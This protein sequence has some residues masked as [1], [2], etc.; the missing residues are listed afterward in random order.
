[1]HEV[2]E[3]RRPLNRARFSG[4]ARLVALFLT[5]PCLFLL[6]KPLDFGIAFLFAIACWL[7]VGPVSNP[8][9]ALAGAFWLGPGIVLVNALAGPQPRLWGLLS[10]AGARLG[11]A[12]ALRLLW[13]AA[14]AH[15]LVRTCSRDEL[16]AALRTVLR[17][18]HIPERHAITIF[19]TLQ[20]L[21]VFST[22]R[23]AE[24]RRLPQAIAERI[25]AGGDFAARVPEP[26]QPAP[27]RLLPAD[28][29]L[30]T[31]AAGLTVLAVLV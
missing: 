25:A 23:V 12:L 30:I 10:A 22:I 5:L 11:L 18:L 16:L 14:L 26:M 24:L 8:L 28:S 3:G 15:A 20:I 1:M 29:L 31:A 17:F 2:P 4:L 9:P 6:D 13:A 21:P 27:G 7:A 19:L